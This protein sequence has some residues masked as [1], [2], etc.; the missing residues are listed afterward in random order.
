MMK[1][2]LAAI[3]AVLCL[4]SSMTLLPDSIKNEITNRVAI[5]ASAET[6]IIL[7]GYNFD[8][9]SYQYA[10]SL[11]YNHQ[12]QIY[13]N[14]ADA[15]WTTSDGS[16]T[17][18]IY[19]LN[20]TDKATN[21]QVCETEYRIGIAAANKAVLDFDLSKPV[22]VIDAIKEYASVKGITVEGDT[23]TIIPDATFASSGNTSYIKTI[24]LTGVVY[25]GN[26]AFN[27]CAYI[28]EITIPES[29]RFVGTSVFEG[30]GLKTLHVKNDMPVVPDGMCCTTALTDVD[31]AHPEFIR[32]V[33]Q[34]AFMKTSLKAPV[35][36]SW[37]DVSE[38]EDD[39][40]ISDSAYEECPNITEVNISDNI[41]LLT[42]SVFR[43]CIKVEKVKFGKKCLGADRECFS[44]C[45]SLVDIQ[46]NDVLEALGGGCFQ[47]CTSLKEV[48]GMPNTM[49][50][51]TPE[52]AT[53]GWGFGG[54]MFA[55]CTSLE[56]VELP[57][58]ISILPKQLFY[59]CTSLVSFYGNDNIVKIK[60]GAFQYCKHLEKINFDKVLTIENNAFNG[61]TQILD[62]AFPAVTNIG[63]MAFKDCSSMTKFNINDD[64]EYVGNNALE[65]CKSL[66]EIKLF[67]KDYGYY[68]FK[69]CTAAKKISMNG[70]GIKPYVTPGGRATKILEPNVSQTDLSYGLFR[71]CSSLT[72]L[73]ADISKN[74]IIPKETFY[75]CTSLENVDFPS[76]RIIDPSA[77]ENC[78]AL[79]KINNS[80]IKA[81]DYGS[82]CFYNCTSL[83]SEVEGDI[84]TIGG[85]AFQNSGITKV[86]IEGMVGG[87]VVIGDSAFADCKN[88]KDA[89]VLSSNTA[90][91]K[92]GNSI[93]QN[94][95]ELEKAEFE[96][97]IITDRMFY[98]CPKLKEVFTSATAV[99]QCAFEKC[100]ALETVK[101][102]ANK[103]SLMKAL[104]IGNGAFRDCASLITIPGDK[105]T[106][107][108]GTENFK[109]CTSLTSVNISSLT[110]N[111]FNGCTK[112][113]SANIN[114]L[115]I[116]PDGAFQN[117]TSLTDI[118]LKEASSIG[119][120]SF[121]KS[122]L[123]DLQVYD[124]ALISN[125]AFYAC[126][127][128]ASVD[129]GTAK[130]DQSAF[131]ECPKLEKV[132]IYT[133]SIGTN[134]FYK[135]NGL[136]SVTLMSGDEHKLATI[137]SNAFAN[138]E[139]LEEAIIAGSPEF[140]SKCIGI[141][142]N[143][144]LPTFI[145]VGDTGSSVQNYADENEIK[146]ADIKTY[147]SSKRMQYFVTEGDVDGNGVIDASDASIVLA[148]YASVQTGGQTGFSE[149]QYATADVDGNDVI[150]ASDASMILSY[151][152][153]TQTGGKDTFADFKAKSK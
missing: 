29:V 141:I 80:S 102:L 72:F 61:C 62:V 74:E 83:T 14:S 115:Q 5:S 130:V 128:L 21:K 11:M 15:K 1:R 7:P 2:T 9:Y 138:C 144:P 137:G 30:S 151:Y 68:V 95:I 107:F 113:K 84:S 89:V 109:N 73:D 48:K 106:I 105:N 28:T 114:G 140:A 94:C 23:A 85:S 131:A 124:A 127:E 22:E 18:S 36:N 42:K 139:S 31:F 24:D 3:V 148:A 43:N 101:N 26:R 77:F 149:I 60:D 17:Y 145:M 56:K 126:P 6:K 121:S 32:K 19:K 50:D 92:V 38:Y 104:T 112:I 10:D 118:D 65:G 27:N 76:A 134:A 37:T 97:K 69:D 87:T 100:A 47:K 88:L 64:C 91:F 153:Y 46:F 143:K 79:K 96:G 41:R 98:N 142:N 75:G 20:V 99:K 110:T 67:A 111:M 51:W 70:A 136:K 132:K 120:Y 116:I 125:N 57:S 150:D 133:E 34:K 16:L 117:C 147:D 86:N 63:A 66:T 58:S 122:G 12:I 81:E 123:T 54:A 35:F 8:K 25:I 39:V 53:E 4:S 108:E 82:R 40:E 49:V 78:T 103:S 152:S 52:D 93:F 59:N 71:G 13:D 45:T 33:G 129:V 146:F 135:C 44:G 119:R 90:E 55:D